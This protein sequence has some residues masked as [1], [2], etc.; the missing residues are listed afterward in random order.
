MLSIQEWRKLLGREDLTDAE[1][2]AF[3][4]DLRNFLS[5]FLDDYLRD[6][7]RPDEV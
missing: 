5:A 6:E 1:V 4:Q 3:V 7:F 2:T